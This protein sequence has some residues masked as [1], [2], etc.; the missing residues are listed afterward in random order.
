MKLIDKLDIN[1][2]DSINIFVPE[3]REKYN[4]FYKPSE[5]L[6]ICDQITIKLQQKE[7]VTELAQNMFDILYKHFHGVLTNIVKDNL[8]LPA[9]VA[10]GEVGYIH[11]MD[12]ETD[13]DDF[14]NFAKFSLCNNSEIMTFLYSKND[15]IYLEVSPLYPWF[16]QEPEPHEEYIPFREYIKAYKPIALYEISRETAQ[17]WLHQC[18]TIMEMVDKTTIHNQA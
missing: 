11:N 13:N 2:F 8:F 17:K 18:E 9:D 16:Y 15:K 5:S 3:L 6:H 12:I 4:Y 1:E 7:S 14:Y 10:V